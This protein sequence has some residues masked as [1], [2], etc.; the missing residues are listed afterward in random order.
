MWL[1]NVWFGLFVAVVAGYLVL[2]GFDLGVGML[3]PF[4]AQDDTERRVVLNSIGPIWD[5]NEVWL[6]VAGGV[7]F[8]A[9]PI[10][11]AALLSGFYWAMMLL[12][13]GLI[14]RAVAIEF[15]SKR[16]SAAWR[17]TWDLVFSLSS[18]ALAVLLGVAFGNIV[19]GVPVNSGGQVVI[20]SLLDVLHPFALLFGVVTVAMLALYGAVF[21]DLKTEGAI[22]ARSRQAMAPLAV[23][24]VL[25]A[26][27][28]V[29]WMAVAGYGIPRSYRDHAWLFV[30]PAL[31]VAAGVAAGLSM[32]RRRD[33][34]GF[35][36]SAAAI[37]LLLVSLAAGLY[38]NL[39]ISNIDAKYSMTLSNAASAGETL[40]V[41]LIVAAIGLPFVLLYTAGVQYL[42]RGKVTLSADSY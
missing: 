30:L 2:D 13:I 21:I 39:L 5:G 14:L 18:L 31:A 8:G 36:W 3:L 11:Y 27:L 24:F 32:V 1:N 41:M 38:P 40:T 15:R 25:L 19:S 26:A 33:V 42:F 35:F 22:Q 9:F 23:A 29:V 12:L 37:V 20:G 7:L 17:T 34:S 28:A 10:V 16:E 4:V 6:V